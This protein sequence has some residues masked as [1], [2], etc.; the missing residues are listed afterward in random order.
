MHI[1]LVSSLTPEDEERFAPAALDAVATF[2]DRLNIA[3][4]LRIEAASGAMFEARQAGTARPPLERDAIVQ[5]Q[6][7]GQRAEIASAPTVEPV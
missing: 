3:Y 2:L 6:G 4:L 5:L 1:R 7:P